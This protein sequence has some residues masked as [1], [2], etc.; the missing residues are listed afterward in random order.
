MYMPNLSYVSLKLTRLGT[1]DYKIIS[2]KSL[3]KYICLLYNLY[4]LKLLTIQR[5]NKSQMVNY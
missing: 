4:Y 1:F 3:K 2:A 5:K